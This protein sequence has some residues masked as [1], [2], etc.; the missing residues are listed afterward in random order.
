MHWK[1]EA[2]LTRDQLANERSILASF[3]CTCT[4]LLS[5]ASIMMAMLN[6]LVGS[7]T[8]SARYRTFLHQYVSFL[9]PTVVYL[10][11]V[12]LFVSINGFLRGV[13]NIFSI[14]KSRIHPSVLG[15][16][17]LFVGVFVVDVILL[18][19]CIVLGI[20]SVL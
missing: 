5:G 11:S 1:N 6:V 12:G 16:G 3:R 10:M 18:K 4:S 7:A 2:S 14:P 9:K 15:M 17:L 13:R 19:E 20:K 8:N